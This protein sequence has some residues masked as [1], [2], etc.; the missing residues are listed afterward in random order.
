M[1]ATTLH[2][3]DMAT[4][5]SPSTGKTTIVEIIR[6]SANVDYLGRDMGTK[7][8]YVKKIK[9]AAKLSRFDSNLENL[10]KG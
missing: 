4:Y 5:T 6:V 2:P 3:G 10:T 1:D 9:G 7:A 8:A